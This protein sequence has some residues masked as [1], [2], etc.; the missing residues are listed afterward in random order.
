MV[1][2]IK[3]DFNGVEGR[4]SDG[5]PSQMQA[6]LA[7]VVPLALNVGQHLP[8]IR[9]SQAVGFV[10]N[11][12]QKVGQ[13]PVQSI[14]HGLPE[15]VK[16]SIIVARKLCTSFFHGGL[17]CVCGG[18]TGFCCWRKEKAEKGQFTFFLPHLFLVT[19]LASYKES[20]HKVICD[21]TVASQ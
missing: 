17:G 18:P 9:R 7:S 20:V 12:G 19:S 6:L 8:D 16:V 3:R 4:C 15:G 5:R 11:L 1:V 2:A 21:V 14:L 13:V 10:S